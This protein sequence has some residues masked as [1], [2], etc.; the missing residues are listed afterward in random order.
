MAPIQC[1][2]PSGR[3]S[4]TTLA[5]NRTASASSAARTE[6]GREPSKVSWCPSPSPSM[7]TAE[8]YRPA[9]RVPCWERRAVRRGVEPR[10]DVGRGLGTAAGPG[11]DRGRVVGLLPRVRAGRLEASLG[12]VPGVGL[13]AVLYGA[14]HVGYGMGG[15]EMAFLVGLARSTPSP[16]RR[17]RCESPPQPARQTPTPHSQDQTNRCLATGSYDYGEAD[18]GRHHDAGRGR[19][20]T[21]PVSYTHLRAHE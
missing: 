1:W 17:T 10:S 19:A 13:A 12:T 6:D 5:K 3:G 16:N 21:H 20:A 14:Y 2:Q 8:R 18:P 9:P 15:K 7:A 4:S 11:H